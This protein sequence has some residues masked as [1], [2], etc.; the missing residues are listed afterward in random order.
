MP[1]RTLIMGAAGRDFHNFN[2]FFRENPDYQVVAFTAT[3]IPNIEDRK[4]P[5]ALSGELYPE[6]IP[7]FP[8]S[9]L[10]GLINKHKVEQVIFA[11]SDVTHEFVMHRASEV[12]AAGADFRLMGLNTTQIESTKPVVSVCAV[13][14]G[15]GKSQTTHTNALL[16]REKNTNPILLMMCWYLPEWIMRQFSGKLKKK[17]M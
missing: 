6:G 16:K 3:Q 15:S 13:R 5:A 8:E 1:V 2:V 9:E 12:L 14:T 10:I 4:Y 17:Q 11:Y 7:I